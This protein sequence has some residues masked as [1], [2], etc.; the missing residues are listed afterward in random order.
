M[1]AEETKEKKDGAGCCG[2][3][4]FKGMSEMMGKFR[5]G[6]GGFAC[7]SMIEAMKSRSCCGPEAEEAKSGSEK[8]TKNSCC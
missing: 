4:S 6:K 8:K 1:C 7:S 5:T 2:S 3:E